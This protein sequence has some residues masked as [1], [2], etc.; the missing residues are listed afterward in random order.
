[1]K[2][3]KQIRKKNPICCSNKKNKIPRNKPNQ[4]GKRPMLRKLQNAEESN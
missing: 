4:R 1:M 2:Y 3:Q